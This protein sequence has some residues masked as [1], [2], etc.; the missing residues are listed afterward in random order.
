[1]TFEIITILSL[2]LLM[3]VREFIHYRQLSRLQELLKSS[4]IT[5]YYRAKGTTAVASPSD[6]KVME[7]DNNI[8]VNEEDF[9][10][11]KASSVII[12]GVETPISII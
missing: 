1:M 10:I 6:N 3:I 12:D 7:E 11:R 2:V 8:S 9:D 4:D 5:E